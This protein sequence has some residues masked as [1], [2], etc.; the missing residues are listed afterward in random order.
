MIYITVPFLDISNLI[1]FC[2]YFDTFYI[3]ESYN[4][5]DRKRIAK[6]Y[7]SSKSKYTHVDTNQ[8]IET[9]FAKKSFIFLLNGFG[10]NSFKFTVV[11]NKWPAIH[12]DE[13]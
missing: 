9:M 8:S 1:L 4:K 7:K 12:S 10:D 2:G 6:L 11:L 13:D 3:H 5:T